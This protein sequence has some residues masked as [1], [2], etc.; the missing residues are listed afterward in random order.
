MFSKKKDLKL[1]E[2]LKGRYQ[3]LDQNNSLN[4]AL[5]RNINSHHFQEK[6]EDKINQNIDLN[7]IKRFIKNEK[8]PDQNEDNIKINPVF[9]EGSILKELLHSNPNLIEKVNEHIVKQQVLNE[10]QLPNGWSIAFTSN[11]RKYFIDHNTQTTHWSHPLEKKNLP[12]GWE[13]IE[14]IEHGIYYVK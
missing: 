6:E 3:K 8:Y 12:V 9:E 10:E 11:G 14:S 1:Q 13:K 4:L 5:V 7:K 2:G